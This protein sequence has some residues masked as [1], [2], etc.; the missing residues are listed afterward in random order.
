MVRWRMRSPSGIEGRWDDDGFA[1]V[2]AEFQ[3]GQEGDPD[4][5]VSSEP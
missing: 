4:P 2:A 5:D 3:E 1:E